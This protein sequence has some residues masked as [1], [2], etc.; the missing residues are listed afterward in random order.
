MI[1]LLTSKG[2][3]TVFKIFKNADTGEMFAINVD[4]IIECFEVRSDDKTSTVIF[5]VNGEKWY[6]DA[7]FQ[8]VV[9]ALNSNAHFVR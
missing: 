9:A 6:V 3:T 5:A 7:S 8:D 1:R 2:R 4:Q